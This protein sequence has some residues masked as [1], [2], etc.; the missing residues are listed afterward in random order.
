MLAEEKV[1]EHVQ[2]RAK[3]DGVIPCLAMK[4]LHLPLHL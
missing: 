2:E 4:S 1:K 3:L